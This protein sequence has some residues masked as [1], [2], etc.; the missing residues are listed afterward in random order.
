MIKNYP[1]VKAYRLVCNMCNYEWIA[2]DKLPKVC[3][4]CKTHNWN[5]PMLVAELEC[6]QPTETEF[7]GT[8]KKGNFLFG[9]TKKLKVL[10]DREYRK[11]IKYD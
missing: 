7:L 5:K 10:S 11:Y 4:S 3:A 2:V 6:E 8:N 1:E 9:K